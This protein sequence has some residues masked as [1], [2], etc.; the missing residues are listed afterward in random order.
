MNIKW[1]SIE[2][3][4]VLIGIGASV[5][6]GGVEHRNA[7]AFK[8][9]PPTHEDLVEAKHCLELWVKEQKRKYRLKTGNA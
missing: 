1:R 2:Q 8:I 9:L 4:G 6:V 7:V 3:M 5:T